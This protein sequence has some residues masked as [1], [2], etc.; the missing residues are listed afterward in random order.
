MIFIHVEGVEVE[1]LVLELWSFRDLPAHADEDVAHALHE[2]VQRVTSSGTPPSRQRS[3]IDALGS[4]ARGFLGNLKLRLTGS[5]CLGDTTTSTAHQ[6]A[7]GGLLIARYV[8]QQ[9]VELGEGRR[10]PRVRSFRCFQ[11]G[12][13]LGDG[14]RGNCRLR[15]LGDGTFCYRCGF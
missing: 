5:E 8:T 9:P 7:G 2:E 1:P 10:L 14:E 15:C 11:G 4:K 13:R 12:H 3:D 6:L